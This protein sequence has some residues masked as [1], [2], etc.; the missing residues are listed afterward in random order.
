MVFATYILCTSHGAYIH[1]FDFIDESLSLIDV[2]IDL[3]E[4]T[5]ILRPQLDLAMH[6]CSAGMTSSW[7]NNAFHPPSDGGEFGAGVLNMSPGWF[8]QSQDVSLF[9]YKQPFCCVSLFYL[10]KAIG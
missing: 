10:L 7:R 2:Q 4:G 3:D 8:Q 6:S 9:L 1:Q 5:K